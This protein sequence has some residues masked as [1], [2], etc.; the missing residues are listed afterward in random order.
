MSNNTNMFLFML[1]CVFICFQNVALGI[2]N[3]F[4]WDN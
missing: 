4:A 1:P 2:A 3:I